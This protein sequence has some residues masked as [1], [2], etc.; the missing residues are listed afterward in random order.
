MKII[1]AKILDATHLELSQ[2]IAAQP[3]EV[4]VIAVPDA[5]EEEDVWRAAAQKH[6]FA[7]YDDQDAI[8]DEL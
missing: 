2:P 1:H 5:Q 3:G 8:Y 4:I 7:A 6:F